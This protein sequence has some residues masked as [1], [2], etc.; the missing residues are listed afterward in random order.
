MFSADDHRYMAR[1]LQLAERGRF[2][3]H[4]NPRVGCVIVSNGDVVGEGFHARAGQGH[5]EVNALAQAGDKSRGA[6]VYVTLEPCSHQGRTPPCAKALINAGVAKVIAAMVDPNPQ[7][8]GRGLRLLEEAGVAT[9]SGLLEV[10]ATTLN[11]GFIRRMSQQRP[12]V[13][14][15]MAG[16]LD[17]RTA[18]A[19]GDSIWITGP[20]AREDVQ[21][22][23]AQA[24][25]VI[26]GIGTVLADDP[27][28]NVRYEVKRPYADRLL[29]PVRI[30]LDSQLQTPLDAKIISIEGPVLIFADRAAEPSRMQALQDKGVEVVLVDRDQDGLSL[31]GVMLE[32][33]KREINECHLECG[34]KLAAAFVQAQLVDEM[35][36]YMAPCLMGGEA[37]PLLDLPIAKM[38]DKLVMRV[39]AVDRVGEDL[40]FTMVMESSLTGNV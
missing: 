29:Q 23:R 15:K 30:I 36:Y 11:P 14:L 20:E 13:R 2:S 34:A 22:L 18:M 26:T 5:A 37:R 32:L 8:S 27:S 16:S 12:F 3:T 24:D 4:P 39:G 19:D 28:L 7:V 25:A 38:T 17:G 21:R 35:I 1:A 6:T 31:Q 10:Q 40:R 9:A 33:T